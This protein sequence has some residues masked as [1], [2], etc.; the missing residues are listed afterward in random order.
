MT[1]KEAAVVLKVSQSY[2]FKLMD[3]GEIAFERRGGI[4]IAG[5]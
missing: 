1:A 3:L 5:R 2:I 4:E